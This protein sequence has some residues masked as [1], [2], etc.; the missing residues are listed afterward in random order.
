MLNLLEAAENTGER[1]ALF[2]GRQ[3]N[4]V[5]IHPRGHPFGRLP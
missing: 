5:P 1:Y 3:A 2:S 4:F